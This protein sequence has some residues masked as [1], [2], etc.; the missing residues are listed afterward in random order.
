MRS[1]IICLWV[2]F[3]GFA[4][5]GCSDDAPTEITRARILTTGDHSVAIGATITITATT[6][7]GTD[8]AYTFTSSAPELFTVNADG[9]V[10]GISDGEGVIS[11]QGNDTGESVDHAVVVLPDPVDTLPDQEAQAFEDAWLLSAHADAGSAAF[12]HWDEDGEI[13]TSCARCHSRDGYIDH[14]GDDGS[15]AGVVDA[16]AALGSTV[17]CETCHTESASTL[18]SVEFP[19]GAV[20]DDLGP[21]ARCMVCH[22]GRASTDSVDQAIADAAV[23]SDDE[24]SAELSIPSNHYY[25]AG[26]TLYA[27][28][29]R[30]GYQYSDELYDVRFRH[31]EGFDSCVGC[32][33]AHSL[34]VKYDAC[35]SCHPGA[36]DRNGALNIRMIASNGQDYDGDGDTEEG[37]FYELETL[38]A[39]LLGVIRTYAAGLGSPICNSPNDYPYWFNDTDNDGVCGEEETGFD[40]RYASWSAR[41]IRAA[42]NS[43]M[44]SAEPG[45]FAHNAK[46]IIQLLHD[47]IV[48]LNEGVGVTEGIDVSR[49]TRTD[50]VHFNGASVAARR[51]DSDAEVTSSC[52]TCHSGEPGYSFFVEFGVGLTVP[53]TSN[54]LECATCHSSFGTEFAVREDVTETVFPGG[55]VLA[56]D[57]EENLCSTC[58]SGRTGKGDIDAIIASGQLRFSNVHYRAA[59]GTTNGSDAQVGYEYDGRTY[60]GRLE[61]QGGVECTSCHDPVESN[62]TFS[63]ASVFEPRCQGCHADEDGPEEVRDVNRLSDYDGDPATTLLV[64]ELA[65]VAERLADALV[66]YSTSRTIDQGEGGTLPPVCYDSTSFPYFFLDT[67][68]SGFVCDDSEAIFP[69]AFQR[70][71]AAMLK[72]VHNYQYFQ[73]EPGAYAHNFDYMFQLL[74]DSVED[75]STELGDNSRLTGLV[76]PDP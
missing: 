19:S 70:W 44:A 43:Q 35:V 49:L 12:T 23:S 76:R 61:H 65:T 36:T 41:L 59:A 18:S 47:S 54:G 48:D 55:V 57:P 62:H 7:D 69:N 8:S 50:G 51:W 39:T 71:D 63:I 24:V 9:V 5:G 42:Y 72:A 37:I 16:P 28:E 38:Q 30:G 53:E 27:G 66:A 6:E 45:A 29:V 75:L 34:Q 1:S 20:V 74:F 68:G 31:V 11:V 56:N 3:A 73:T 52:S 21:E 10:T 67:D 25:P 46:Y 13:P 2:G 22:Q 58:H 32:H 40:N 17:D 33:D 26:A 14:L 15:P 64:D 60:T 4:L